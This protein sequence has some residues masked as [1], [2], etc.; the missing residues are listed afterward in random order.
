MLTEVEYY[1]ILFM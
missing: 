1:I